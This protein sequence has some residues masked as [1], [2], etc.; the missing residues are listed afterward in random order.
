M[1]KWNH[2]DDGDD[3]VVVSVTVSMRVNWISISKKNMFDKSQTLQPEAFD[4][5]Q[6]PWPCS[7]TPW[8]LDCARR[9]GN[10]LWTKQSNYFHGDQQQEPR[11]TKKPLQGVQYLQESASLTRISTSKGSTFRSFWYLVSSSSVDLDSSR[12]AFALAKFCSAL[13]LNSV[14]S[15]FASP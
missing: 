4:W 7:C 13:L 15:S 2:G 1:G 14:F 6:T 10:Q 11:M 3:R 12:S 9:Y 8:W 5:F